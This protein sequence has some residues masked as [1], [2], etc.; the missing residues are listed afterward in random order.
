VSDII[1]STLLAQRFY[2][3][4]FSRFTKIVLS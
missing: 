1:Y 2:L 4:T 3:L